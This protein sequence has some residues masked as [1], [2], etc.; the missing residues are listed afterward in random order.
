MRQTYSSLENTTWVHVCSSGIGHL[1]ASALERAMYSLCCNCVLCTEQDPRDSPSQ[2]ESELCFRCHNKFL[3]MSGQFSVGL[4]SWFMQ[5]EP[6]DSGQ[7]SHLHATGQPPPPGPHRNST[8]VIP[9]PFPAPVPQSPLT[10]DYLRAR[11]GAG[12]RHQPTALRKGDS[13]Q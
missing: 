13:G 8:R 7:P 12:L 6:R 11:P 4:I 5:S 10:S 2:A 3:P 9:S 1:L